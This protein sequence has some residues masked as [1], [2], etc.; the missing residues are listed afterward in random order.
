MT[1]NPTACPDPLRCRYRSLPVGRRGHP[2]EVTRTA[3]A[4]GGRVLHA[5]NSSAI[6]N[7]ELAPPTTSTSPPGRASGLRWLA[8]WTWVT[9]GS[10]PWAVGG[11]KGHLEGP[12]GHNDLSCVRGRVG[13]TDL[14]PVVGSGKA[15][16]PGVEPNREIE[17]GHIGLE[18]VG[19]RVLG[20]VGVGRSRERH[21]GQAVVLGRANNLSESHRSRQLWP[22]SDPASSTTN[23]NPWRLR[24]QAIARRAWPPPIT[25]ASSSRFDDAFCDVP[26]ICH[27]L[28]DRAV[29]GPSAI[30]GGRR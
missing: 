5:A 19:H 30:S 3:R 21:A 13:C 18:V 4:R 11:T 15:D 25:T 24:C 20:R 17:G 23:H 16:H 29:A 8:L 1:R 6:W 27:S 12:G 10:S 7:P 14:E 22:S 26:C 9:D 28:L 2:A